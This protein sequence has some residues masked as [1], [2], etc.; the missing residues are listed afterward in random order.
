M[1]V[2]D[3]CRVCVLMMI[4]KGALSLGALTG[5]SSEALVYLDIAQTGGNWLRHQIPFILN[6]TSC[7]NL[8]HIQGSGSFKAHTYG[9]PPNIENLKQPVLGQNCTF[10]DYEFKRPV[11][12]SSLEG[13]GY[14]PSKYMVLSSF[15]DPCSHFFASYEHAVTFAK[16]SKTLSQYIA[17]VKAGH[18]QHYD[19]HNFQIK[20][21]LGNET[22][23]DFQDGVNYMKSLYW[24]SVTEELELSLRMLQC[25]VLG[26]VNEAQIQQA[27]SNGEY[28][29][30]KNKGHDMRCTSGSNDIADIKSLNSIDLLFYEFVKKEFWSRV[31]KYADCLSLDPK[32]RETISPRSTKTNIPKVINKIYFSNSGDFDKM[33]PEVVAAHDT[34]TLKNQGYVIHYYNLKQ[35]RAYIAAHISDRTLKA[36]DCIKSYAGKAN[37]FRYIVVYNEG[38]WY[39]D[40]KQVCLKDNLLDSFKDDSLVFCKDSVAG[41]VQNAFFGAT[42]NHNTLKQLIDLTVTNIE[43]K[44]YGPN[45]LS[46]GGSVCAIG[47]IFANNHFL[48][49]GKYIHRTGNFFNNKNEPIVQHKCTNCGSKEFWPNGN[50]YLEL[51]HKKKLYC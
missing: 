3:S 37:L 43:H 7:N 17:D 2:L 13:I 48:F 6:L 23:I 33:I 41:C 15:R 20:F 4:V 42:K 14:P 29:R 49:Q 47:K 18:P 44:V 9:H 40:W 26:N 10:F 51:W 45:D 32:K 5:N 28:T 39:S 24:F 1:K 36:F 35:A 21:M 22:D 50:D 27:L 30:L 16:V 8:F 19:L 25:Q 11:M 12:T 38:G 31:Y 34:W 46:A